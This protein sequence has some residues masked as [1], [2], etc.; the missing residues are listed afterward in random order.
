MGW[1]SGQVLSGIN[2]IYTVQLENGG[3]LQCRIKGKRLSE[4]ERS[5]NP[6]ATGDL[7]EVSPN[8]MISALLP[9]RTW[10]CRWNT[11]GRARQV[12]AA[13]ADVA[14]CVTS[15]QNPPFRPRFIDRLIAAAESGK[16]EALIAINKADLG[17]DEETRERAEDY[18]RIGYPVV[19]CSAVSGEGLADLAARIRGKLAVFVGQ[20]G[21]GKSSLLNALDPSLDLRVG[22]ISRKHDRGSHTTNFSVLLEPRRRASRHRHSRP[23]RAEPLRRASQR[24]AV[25]LQGVR[26]AR[27]R[28]R[29]PRV[30]AR[31]GAG[32]CRTGRGGAGGDSPRQV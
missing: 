26:R 12:L 10:L 15:P 30:P 27:P 31:R 18:R 5:Y 6:I 32:L 11:K 28:L 13:N 22:E 24:V 29:N 23:P 14:V 7:V 9:R 4:D 16:L 25:S 19:C 8:G 2:T 20:S 21:V 1:A 17:I 3:R